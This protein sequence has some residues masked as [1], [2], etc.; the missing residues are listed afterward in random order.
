MGITTGA[1]ATGSQNE[2][3]KGDFSRG[4]SLKEALSGITSTPGARVGGFAQA[5]L[6]TSAGTRRFE[7]FV[8]QPSSLGLG[9][10]SKE[11]NYGLL[12]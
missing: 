12:S 5:A 7:N 11:N 4:I 3:L 2:S 9:F 1:G 10:A 6:K 8:D